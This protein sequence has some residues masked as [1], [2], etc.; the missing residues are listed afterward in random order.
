MSKF[1]RDDKSDD[2]TTDNAEKTLKRQQNSAVSELKAFADVNFIGAQMSQ[3]L[4]EQ[5]KNIVGKGENA[6]YQHFLLFPQWLRKTLSPET[7][8]SHHCGY[9][10]NCQTYPCLLGHHFSSSCKLVHSE[11]HQT[12]TCQCKTITVSLNEMNG[13][14][15]P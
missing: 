4:F 9:G 2:G 7:F 6:G 3:F 8:E 1:S 11:I 13:C 12:G 10:S 14:L 15:P 5:V